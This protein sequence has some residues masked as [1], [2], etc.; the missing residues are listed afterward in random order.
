MRAPLP[1]NLHYRYS[2]DCE[3]LWQLAR[4]QLDLF[5]HRHPDADPIRLI[6]F[7]RQLAEQLAPGP[8]ETQQLLELALQDQALLRLPLADTIGDFAAINPQTSLAELLYLSFG[9]Q[10]VQLLVKDLGLDLCTDCGQPI[11]GGD[12]IEPEGDEDDDA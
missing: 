8:Q 5:V 10:L 4:D 3:E 6:D 11:E 1:I 12:V 2:L 7:A 9:N